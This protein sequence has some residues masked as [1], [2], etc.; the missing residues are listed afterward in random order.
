MAIPTAPSV[1]DSITSLLNEEPVEQEKPVIDEEEIESDDIESEDDEQEEHPEEEE[2]EEEESE[3]DDGEH[4]DNLLTE[5][6]FEDTYI[7]IDGEKVNLGDL[8]KGYLRQSD[9][10]KKTT[11]VAAQRKEAETIAA[12]AEAKALE[13]IKERFELVGMDVEKRLRD[14]QKIDWKALARTNPGDYT[15]L[16]ADY[17]ETYAEAQTLEKE[18]REVQAK[19]VEIRNQHINET[20][21]K[22]FEVLS[23]DIPNWGEALHKEMMDYAISGGMDQEIA[24]SIVD[25]P[26]LKLVYKAF[27]YDKGKGELSTKVKLKDKPSV[28]SRLKPKAKVDVTQKQVDSVKQSKVR[29]QLQTATTKVDRNTLQQKLIL[30]LLNE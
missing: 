11:E 26:A 4:D 13:I 25:A 3:E 12:N 22:S 28:K 29:K 15:A 27:M 24:Y 14:F 7:E 19:Q 17:E 10:T 20:A 9:Y 6:Y 2:S 23:K 18:Y 16:K 5:E 1:L 21:K 8:K 30:D